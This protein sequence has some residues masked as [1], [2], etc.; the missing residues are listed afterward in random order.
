MKTNLKFKYINMSK[1]SRKLAVGVILGFMIFGF[2]PVVQGVQTERIRPLDDWIYG[3]DPATWDSTDYW[4][5]H[6]NRRWDDWIK[7]DTMAGNPFGGWG[8]LSDGESNLFISFDWIALNDEIEYDGFVLERAMPDGSLRIGVNLNVKNMYIEVY[9]FAE[10]WNWPRFFYIEELVLVGTMDYQFQTEFILDKDIPGGY[11]PWGQF[12]APGVREPGAELPPLWMTY[13]FG[14]IIGARF[15]SFQFNGIGSGDLVYPGWL[16]PL[17]P[18]FTLWEQP[19][20]WWYLPPAN[21]PEN[22]PEPT[23]EQANVKVNY[24][25]F[26]FPHSPNFEWGILWFT[27]NGFEM[28]RIF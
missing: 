27:N 21:V 25:E 23:G 22:P 6:T 8:A 12:V 17:S 16:P 15:L 14:R 5:T 26:T 18:T 19:E 13:Y 3:N 24:Q 20:F 2:I 9:R 11:F 7:G 1:L 28:V 10:D 4:S